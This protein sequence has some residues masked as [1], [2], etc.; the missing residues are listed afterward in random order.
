MS[1]DWRTTLWYRI[2]AALGRP[3]VYRGLAAALLLLIGIP[4]ACLLAWGRLLIPWIVQRVLEMLNAAPVWKQI[5]ADLDPVRRAAVPTRI[6]GAVALVLPQSAAAGIAGAVLLAGATLVLGH[7]M[8]RIFATPQEPPTGQSAVAHPD[9]GSWLGFT[10]VLAVGM[11]AH[12][13]SILQSLNFDEVNGIIHAEGSVFAPF[14]LVAGWQQHMGGEVLASLGLALFGH[15]D[16]AAHVFAALCSSIGLALLWTW[17]RARRGPVV[18]VLTTALICALPL[19]AEQATLARGYGLLFTAG[20]LVSTAAWD[21][22]D[23]SSGREAHALRR[24]F[25]GSVMGL[26]AHFFFLF[27]AFAWLVL[28]A[29]QAVVRKDERAAAG[30]AW[31]LSG[32]AAP[33]VLY[34]PGLPMTLYQQVGKTS[35]TEVVARFVEAL[36]FEAAEPA[37]TLVA[38]V[39]VA[40][41][42]AGLVLLPTRDRIRVSVV[43]GLTAGIPALLRPVFYYPRFF[44][45]LLPLMFTATLPVAAMLERLPGRAQLP[46]AVVAGLVLWSAPRPWTHMPPVDLRSGADAVRARLRPGEVAAIER[47]CVPVMF[48]LEPSQARL[49]ALARG[50]PPGS[51]VLLAAHPMPEPAPQY[52]GFHQVGAY[53]GREHMIVVFEADSTV[54][55]PTA[56]H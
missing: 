19:W 25:I 55:N 28:F 7:Y 30:I 1:N 29:Q 45:D 32:L 53:P 4:S 35:W 17:L 11:L 34:I 31:T 39:S 22:L 14:N 46:S 54:E 37:R 12:L 18:A 51:R 56:G 38:L 5:I 24:L 13:R 8:H 47:F 36:G 42:I 50:I 9:S 49:A 23:G 16:W 41:L 44:V 33:G 2:P 15:H 10:A 21:L 52:P 26:F 40:M 27:F 6:E 43:I 48:Y 20:V 3:R